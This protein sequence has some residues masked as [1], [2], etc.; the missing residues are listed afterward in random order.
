MGLAS[1]IVRGDGMRKSRLHNYEGER[2]DLGGLCYLP[3]AIASTILRKLLGHRPEVPWLGY[4]AIRR[5]H[6]LIRNDWRLLEFG[7]GMSSLWFARRCRL[8]VSIESDES[9]YARLSRYFTERGLSNIDYRLSTPEEYAC[10]E[11]YADH[12]FDF[13][14]IDGIRRNEAARTAIAKAR[15]GGFVYLDNT[16]VPWDEYRA[17]RETLLRAAGSPH[18]LHYFNDFCPTQCSVHQGLLIQTS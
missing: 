14:L 2:I 3:Q 12:S 15:R 16:D 6:G 10:V 5:L 18:K 13:V 8:L 17:A 7:S 4:R 1:R 9:W 11:D